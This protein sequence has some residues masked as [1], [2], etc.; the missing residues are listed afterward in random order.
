M[1]N[2]VK[3]ST[4][5][6]LFFAFILESFAIDAPKNLKLDSSDSNSVKLSWDKQA[7]AVMYDVYYWTKSSKEWWYDN[8]SDLVEENSMTI[9]KLTPWKYYFSVVAINENTD[10]SW[11]S[12]EVSVNLWWTV[13]TSDF[14]LQSIQ[15]L[16]LN[17]IELSFTKPVEDI[18]NAVREFK[19]SNKMDSL[20]AFDVLKAEVNPTNPKNLLLTLD[21]DTKIN[22]TYEVVIVA[23]KSEDWKNIESGIDGTEVF[24][25][26]DV[27]YTKFENV[28]NSYDP[29]FSWTVDVTVDNWNVNVDL[30]SAWESINTNSGVV[31]NWNLEKTAEK[32]KKLPTTWPKEFVVLLLLSFIIWLGFFIVKIK[33]S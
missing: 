23:I 19:V 4:I 21:K 25:V 9:S 16:W 28:I 14:A 18:E 2:I 15:V 32:S 20:D 27:D 22:N 13:Q 1:K 3:I 11:Y 30:N 29:N 17:K 31:A 26:K 8:Q 6:F 12:N 7:D 24:Q 5:F 10:V 33:K